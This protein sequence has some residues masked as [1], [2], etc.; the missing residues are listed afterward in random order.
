MIRYRFKCTLLSDIVINE[1]AGTDGPQSSLDYIPGS[2]FM[3]IVANKMYKD[4]KDDKDELLCYKMF[5]SGGVRFS[6]AHI[7][8]DGERF[9][10]RP[11]S[12]ATLKNGSDVDVI[13][14]HDLSKE[15]HITNFK[16]GKQYKQTR[17][18]YF[19]PLKKQFTEINKS[20]SLKSAY[21]AEN[22]KAK[23]SSLFGYESIPQGIEM[24]FYVESENKDYLERATEIL[25]GEKRVG[26]SKSAQYG[27]VEIS[28][29][30]EDADVQFFDDTDK[31]EFPGNQIIVYAE[32]DL[33]IINQYGSPVLAPSICSYLN[34]NNDWN[35]CWEKS[36]ILTRSYA[37]WNGKRFTRD[38]DR[39]VISKGSVFV[40]ENQSNGG[41]SKSDEK[42]FFY[43]IGEFKSEGLGGVLINP[44]F[45]MEE[46]FSQKKPESISL[47]D[48]QLN[49]Q[50]FE[51]NDDYDDNVFKYL[52]RINKKEEQE[53]LI[54][55]ACI[56][57]RD[58]E[59]KIYGSG[60]TNSQWGSIR[61]IAKE[62]SGKN[63]LVNRLFEGNMAYLNHGVAKDNWDKKERREKLRKAV[64]S[65]FDGY[66]KNGYSKLYDDEIPEVVEK[67][68]SL[69]QKNN[70]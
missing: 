4:S 58:K 13:L 50:R 64:K 55:S 54:Y 12:W 14:H 61:N 33:C 68:A 35:V 65:N 60:I 19:S 30:G 24:I 59:K 44:D 57:F 56:K 15:D 63:E 40:L 62:C 17:T 41:S 5:H 7:S 20:F 45:L 8:M 9:L 66:I 36:Q 53:A 6:D 42:K 52:K 38:A 22:R 51:S 11:A 29:L 10:R 23:D 28:L 37:P 1:K 67:L 21:D 27:L 39:I 32:S 16:E 3:G 48:S 31:K 47:H 69:F 34:L 25:I 46:Y 70:K 26:R 43:R 2:N 18:G 49:I